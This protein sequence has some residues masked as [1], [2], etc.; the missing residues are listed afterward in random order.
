MV[1]PGRERDPVRNLEGREQ[2]L[3]GRNDVELETIAALQPAVDRRH[4]V[5]VALPTPGEPRDITQLVLPKTL[6]YVQRTDRALRPRLPVDG[7]VGDVDSGPGNESQ[8]W[9][10]GVA[11]P[12]VL[13]V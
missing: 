5:F 2:A 11:D 4:E 1:C 8:R 13:E 7:E 12:L 9:I 10:E 3:T 6:A